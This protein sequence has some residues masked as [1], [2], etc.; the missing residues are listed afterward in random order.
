L[1]SVNRELELA[2]GA[3]RGFLRM[4]LG[5]EIDERRDL[6]KELA[7]LLKVQRQMEEDDEEE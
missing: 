3:V 2:E 5:G 4:E 6:R 7:R 1:P